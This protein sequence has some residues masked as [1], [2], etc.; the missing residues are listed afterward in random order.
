MKQ[1]DIYVKNMT[2][3][4]ARDKWSRALDAMHFL[5]AAKT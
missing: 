5:T 4:E 1:K 2:L 3:D